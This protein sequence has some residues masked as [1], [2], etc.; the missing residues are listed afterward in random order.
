MSSHRQQ[1]HYR[2]H[3]VSS[4][5]GSSQLILQEPHH[6][7]T[8]SVE[9]PVGSSLKHPTGAFGP[10]KQSLRPLAV[11]KHKR[12]SSSCGELRNSNG[13]KENAPVISRGSKSENE[14][15]LSRISHHSSS[16]VPFQDKTNTALTSRE[17]PPHNSHSSSSL[18]ELVPPLNAARL[19]PIQQ[20]TRSAVVSI[21]DA[22]KVCLQF[23]AR[24]GAGQRG[25][26]KADGSSGSVSEIIE[27]SR[28]GMEVR[29]S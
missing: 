12:H 2:H 21:T 29:R 14:K 10:S 1:Q 16:T 22:G 20:K 13:D 19:R 26:R 3:S 24:G 4:S 8:H 15:S 11:H 25:G 6:R 28:N 5:T 27:I 9:N 23:L 18:K 7:R 17:K